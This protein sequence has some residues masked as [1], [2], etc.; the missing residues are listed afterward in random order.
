MLDQGADAIVAAMPPSPAQANFRDGGVHVVIDRD[1]PLRRHPVK[2]GQAADRLAR[3]VHEGQGLGQQDAGPRQGAPTD[4]RIALGPVQGAPGPGSE[5]VDDRPPH[6]V[7][8]P[9]IPGAR[10][11]QADHDPPAAAVR[12]VGRGGGDVHGA[13]GGAAAAAGAQGGEGGAH[14][15]DG[16]WWG[17][18]VGREGPRWHA[19]GKRERGAGEP[20]QGAGSQ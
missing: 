15:R 6:V 13:Q 2:L 3:H 11:A 19:A 7:A 18:G 1:H 20:L 9:G 12:G 10:V 14:G 5:R 17:W 16:G 4:R 8:R